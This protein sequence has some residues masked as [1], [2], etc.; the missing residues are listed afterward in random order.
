M[1]EEVMIIGAGPAGCAAGI[2]LARAGWTVRLFE[3]AEFPRHRPG[4]SLHPGI[5]PLLEKLGVAEAVNA[6]GFLRFP[7]IRVAWADCTER[8]D[9][10]GED[11]RG[12]WLGY[13]A[14]RPKFDAIL[15]EEA[16]ARGVI[17]HQPCRVLKVL[18]EDERVVGVATD[19]GEFRSRWV[20]DG[21]GR[22][23]LLARQL[24][25][26]STAYS[27]PMHASYGYVEG[28]NE[29]CTKFG[30]PLIRRDQSGWTWLARV[31][32]N[33]CAWVTVDLGEKGDLQKKSPPRE[34]QEFGKS[35]RI[36]GADV[37]WRVS[38]R[39]AGE[40]WFLIGDAAGSLD[41]TSAHG[42]LRGIM[43]GMQAASLINSSREQGVKE[44]ECA[45]RYSD[46]MRAWFNED[47]RRMRALN[48]SGKGA[49]AESVRLAATTQTLSN[50]APKS[51]KQPH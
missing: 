7:G 51:S 42:V 31:T 45:R 13:Q 49:D 17:V 48:A 44:G 10:F 11:E 15:L 37:T 38:N 46:W 16:K 27:E 29:A 9:A 40:G 6:A 43:S 33:L 39:L 28:A 12:A 23:S 5:E 20:V 14:W 50:K 18:T 47:M 1:H 2:L 41:P 21:S 32:E 22:R 25:V 8:F 30:I 24:A 4:E 19:Q 26:G 35:H 34:L 3:A 36:R